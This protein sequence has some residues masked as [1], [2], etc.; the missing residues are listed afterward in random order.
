MFINQHKVKDLKIPHKIIIKWLNYH[1]VHI[2]SIL[3]F[4]MLQILIK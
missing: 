1:Q 3:N 4:I 2:H